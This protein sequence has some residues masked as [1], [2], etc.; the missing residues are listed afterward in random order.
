VNLQST[1]SNNSKKH[2]NSKLYGKKVPKIQD[3]YEVKAKDQYKSNSDK[4]RTKFQI[5]HSSDFLVNDLATCS[6][7]N[8]GNIYSL[9]D[10]SQFSCCF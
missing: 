8:T 2:L 10:L 4:K 9:F 5:D 3:A 7:N 6:I 1:K